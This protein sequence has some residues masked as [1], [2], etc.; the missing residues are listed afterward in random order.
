MV[1]R[2]RRR[3]AVFGGDLRRSAR[4]F[5]E[6]D[7]LELFGSSGQTGQGEMR[8]LSAAL[9]AGRVDRVYLVIR[10]AGH[11]DIE[12]IRALCKALG[13]SCES[14]HSFGAVR[15]AIRG[16]EPER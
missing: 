2:R 13:I 16:G 11:K 1:T 4:V 7:D 12:T 14:Y 15:R 5:T 6:R 3:V 8:R 10:W 9:R